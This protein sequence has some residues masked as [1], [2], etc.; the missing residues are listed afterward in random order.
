MGCAAFG[1]AFGLG[2][3]YVDTRF[4]FGH[5]VKA[6]VDWIAT[7]PVAQQKQAAAEGKK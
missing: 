4:V 5:D 3:A 1:S 6:S 2:R 7:V